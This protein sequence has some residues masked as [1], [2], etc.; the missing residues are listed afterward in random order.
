MFAIVATAV[1]GLV[2]LLWSIVIYG[3][4]LRKLPYYW[5]SFSAPRVSNP[6]AAYDGFYEAL[7]K[8]R[9]QKALA[10]ISLENRERYRVLLGDPETR[11]RQL[12]SKSVL[13]ELRTTDCDSGEACRREALYSYEYEVKE[14]FWEEIAGKRFFVP[15]GKQQLEM[16]FI[17][18]PGG[19]WQITEL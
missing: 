14:G 15:P 11:R 10:Y 4:A 17:Q 1:A 7:A 6:Q 9:W 13:T 5:E 19:R 12:S 3:P 2:L 8:E 16:S 18:L